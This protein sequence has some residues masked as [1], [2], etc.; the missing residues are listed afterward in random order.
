MKNSE[1]IFKKKPTELIPHVHLCTGSR[2][3]KTFGL[4]IG[5]IIKEA[6]IENL[7]VSFH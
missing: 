6:E 1:M 5:F 4:K 2:I 7:Y 3:R